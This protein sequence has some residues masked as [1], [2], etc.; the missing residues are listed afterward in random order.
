M[1]RHILE[2]LAATNPECEIWWDSSPLVYENWKRDVLAGAPENKRAEWQDQLNRL[3]NVDTV[4]AMGTMGFGGVTTNPPLSLQAIQN[5]PDFW[6][7]EIRR[8]ADENAGESV[9]VV[10]WKVYLEVAR[11]SAEMIRP[12]YDRSKG[13]YGHVSGQVDPR[14]VTNYDLMLRQGLELAALAPNLMVKIPGSAEGY[15][16]IEE[17]T[18]LGISTNNTTSFTVPQYV[19]CMNAV[20]R[21]LDRARAAG[22][23]LAR[24]RSV[25]TH[26]SARLGNIGD[27]KSQ[28]DLR[29][30]ALTLEEIVLGELAVLKRAY[31]YGKERGHPS[32][33]LQ[34]SM[35][36]T[37]EGPGGKAASWHIQKLAGGDFV[38]TCPPG[39]IAQLMQAE[40]RMDPFDPKA[41]DEDAPAALI[42]KLRRL[43]Y[44]RQAYDFDG[45]QPEEFSQFGAFVATAGEF[46]AATRKTVDFVASAI[47][48]T[49]QHAA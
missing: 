28:A 7:G 17:L 39:Y 27:L 2:N 16:V 11:R 9:E 8:I 49:Q 14:F 30:I 24:W 22:I 45:M 47:E 21:G 32:K 10:Y 25:I 1:T 13:R 5:D 26:M 35:R 40:D 4:E 33:M 38:Y 48:R 3:F 19:A 12:V 34:C 23:D 6:A 20:S 44:F 31:R 42:E 29:G 46:A 43:P 36:V 41:I 15:R 18:A 37:D